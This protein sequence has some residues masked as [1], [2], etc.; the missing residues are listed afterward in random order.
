[1]QVTWLQQNNPNSELVH[2]TLFLLI[3]SP[4]W[5]WAMNLKPAPVVRWFHLEKVGEV[6]LY[7]FIYLFLL[8]VTKNIEPNE[9]LFHS[10]NLF[11]VMQTEWF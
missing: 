2:V 3:F 4:F 11:S 9:R 7:Y 10:A 5:V 8:L 1:M 6:F